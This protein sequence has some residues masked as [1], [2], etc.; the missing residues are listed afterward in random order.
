[1]VKVYSTSTCPWCKKA[2]AYFDEK[3]IAYESVDVS[4]NS[5]AQKE[6]IEKSGQMGVPVIDIDGQIVVGFD[7]ERID[8]LLKVKSL[9]F[10]P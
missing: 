10:K 3:G 7:K 9:I 1:M 6:M 4:L 8:E 2:K 5:E